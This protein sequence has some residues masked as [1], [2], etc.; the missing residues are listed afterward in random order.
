MYKRQVVLHCDA[1]QAAGKVPI[2]VGALEVDLLSLTAHK[3]YGPKGIG[4]LYIRRRRP[5]I[6]LEPM[7]DGGGHE[8][9]YRSGTLNVP[10]VGG[11]SFEK[12]AEFCGPFTRALY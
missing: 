10:G 7:V 4:A 3:I 11:I 1:A 6:Q 12:V 2:D 8:Q 5:R 9:G